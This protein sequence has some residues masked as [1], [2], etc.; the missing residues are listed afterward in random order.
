MTTLIRTSMLAALCLT[1]TACATGD[2]IASTAVDVALIP[3]KLVGKGVDALT[4]SDE[5]KRLEA[6]EH[7]RIDAETRLHIALSRWADE[8]NKAIAGGS[9][10]APKPQASEFGLD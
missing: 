8:C 9:E 3:A 4:T 10:C 2:K 7:A 1:L 6:E 5:E